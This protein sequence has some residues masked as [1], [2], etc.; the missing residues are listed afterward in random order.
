MYAGRGAQRNEPLE[1]YR[2]VIVSR[3]EWVVV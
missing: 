2:A 3:D 1:P